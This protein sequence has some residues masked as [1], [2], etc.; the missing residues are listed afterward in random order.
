MAR[1]DPPSKFSF[2][3]DDWKDWIAE[4]QRYRRAVKLYADDGADQRDQLLYAMGVKEAE[5]IFKTFRFK[6]VK[7]TKADGSEEDYQEKDTDF[8]CLV[9]KF[10][11]HFVLMV[12][13]RYERRK[14]NERIQG[15]DEAV[16]A[17]VRAL[18]SLVATCKYT[19]EDDMILDRLIAGLK[20]SRVR[21]KLQIY[22][23]RDNP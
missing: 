2:I 13:I 16:E 21:A 23:A 1:F 3:A 20:D 12:N 9:A 19:D 8:D 22:G 14:F 18:Y 10:T 4:Y 5:K 7:R 15:K 17:F 11:N 6:K